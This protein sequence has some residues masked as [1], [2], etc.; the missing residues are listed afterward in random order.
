VFGDHRTVVQT[1]L[2]G[3]RV[4]WADGSSAHAASTGGPWL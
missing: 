4:Q 2:A 1:R 3:V